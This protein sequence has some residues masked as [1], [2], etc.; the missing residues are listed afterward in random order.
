MKKISLLIISL[1]TAIAVQAQTTTVNYLIVAGGGGGGELYGGGGGAGGVLTGST[2]VSAGT[3]SITVG[4]G[5][6]GALNGQGNGDN[7]GNSVFNSLTA[8]GGGGGAAPDG[9]GVTGGSGGG[10]G[11][12]GGSDGSGTTGEGYNGGTSYDGIYGSS[13]GGGG[14][15]AV[16]GDGTATGAG[17]GGIGISS[18]IS[19]SP[20]YY[21]GGGGG[22][23]DP[24]GTAGLGGN[25]GGG[26]GSVRSTSAPTSGV[27]NTGGGGGGAVSSQNAGNGGS[28]IVIISFAS[29]GI[30]FTQS[31]GVV[32]TSGANTI[33]TFNSSGTFNVTGLVGLSFSPSSPAICIG[34]STS[35][36]AGGASTYTWTPGTGLNTTNGATVL[37]NPTATTV[38]TVSG[39][40]ANNCLATQQITLTVNPLPVITTSPANPTVSGGKGVVITAGGAST[41]TWAPEHDLS[42][43]NGST[44]TASPAVTSNYTITGTSS[45]GCI[46]STAVVVN[47]ALW[48]Q[49]ADTGSSPIS[50]PGF[51]GIGNANPQNPLDVIGNARIA[52][53]LTANGLIATN[54]GLSVSTPA[55]FT[56]TVTISSLA[57]GTGLQPI[58]VDSAG[59]L[60]PGNLT[61]ANPNGPPVTS[62]APCKTGNPAWLT[63][64]NTLNAITNA[65]L[66]TCDNHDL[67]FEANS[68]QAI[69]LKPSGLVGIATP[70]PGALLHIS[71]YNSTT[72][73]GLIIDQGNPDIE[74]PPEFIVNNDGSTAIYNLGIPGTNDP[75]SVNL[76]NTRQG[77]TQTLVSN[78]FRVAANG[79][80]GIGSNTA[81]NYGVDAPVSTSAYKALTVS[82][83]VSLANYNLSG[84]GSTTNGLNGIEILGNSGVPTRRGIS[85]DTDPDA[86]FNFYI[87]SSEPNSQFNFVNGL[88][89]VV[90]STNPAL[91]TIGSDG[92]TSIYDASATDA[93]PLLTLTHSNGSTLKFLANGTGD[94]ASSTSLRPHF[95][96][97]DFTIYEGVPGTGQLRLQINSSAAGGTGNGAIILRSLDPMAGND[98]VVI[99]NNPQANGSGT[100]ANLFEVKNDGSTLIT[101]T[102]SSNAPLTIIQNQ[103]SG[104]P[105]TIFQVDPSGNITSN[106]LASTA[107]SP[108]RSLAV[109]PS[110]KIVVGAAAG[111]TGSAWVLGGNASAGSTLG[112]TDNTDLILV[113]GGPNL[114]NGYERMRVTSAG[115]IGIGAAINNPQSLLDISGSASS[116]FAVRSTNSLLTGS[117]AWKNT[118]FEITPTTGGEAVVFI[119]N[120]RPGTA[121]FNGS[122]ILL[123]VNGKVVA[124]EVYVAN[125]AAGWADYVFKKD[126][127]LMPLAEVEKYI[128]SNKHLP[129]LPSATEVE[130]KGQ[131]LG[132]L[133]VKQMEKI[134]ELTLYLI[135]VNKELK[136]Q[137]TELKKLQEQNK[138]LVSE[139]ADLKKK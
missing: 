5:G 15:G 68:N 26:A 99:R 94:I 66:G 11:Y 135:E 13:G 67:V 91:L 6:T 59:N 74:G 86:D 45:S 136:A 75:F 61:P 101:S 120:K 81:Y 23:T 2:S 70:Y 102:S 124:Q 1:V 114:G 36:T 77:P 29:C 93:N 60:R 49:A 83:D 21:A 84:H 51:V 112:T 108:N 122:N 72:V 47:V 34:A 22:A 76:Q 110:G 125:T 32:S 88:H 24:G 56:K 39:T 129:N 27:A 126:Y 117:N 44:V 55:L 69:W 30:S 17:N 113:A 92:S 139:L 16:G 62:V 98:A 4:A 40:N 127:S 80:V 115:N 96:N 8:I 53:N 65:V 123:S 87:N 85:V 54:T 10:Q 106:A 130:A 90:S 58:Y 42:S 57:G 111:S 79:N 63:G 25:G 9:S 7:G 50:Y 134:E 104:T 48:K 105:A 118:V 52:G 28:G 73:P 19:G 109:D 137:G 31:G 138:T 128:S 82:G 89:G 116:F 18:S 100:D 38:Y 107:G 14:A 20:V 43:T 97:G 41:Y 71:T 131:N 119:G 132:D 37:A 46:S 133:Q 12:V 95:A 78:V 35:I 64:G 33:I 121:P 3:Y 103:S